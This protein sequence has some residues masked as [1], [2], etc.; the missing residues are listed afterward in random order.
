MI[1]KGSKLDCFLGGLGIGALVGL[2]FAPRSGEESRDYLNQKVEEGK[3]Y[4]QRKA[5]EVRERAEDFVERGKQ[6]VAEQKE[7]ISEAVDAGVEAYHREK[8]KEAI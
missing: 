2:L 5:L 7:V 3:E 6:I 4:A 8:S 1:G